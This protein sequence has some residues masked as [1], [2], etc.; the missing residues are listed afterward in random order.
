[1]AS[2]VN[3]MELGISAPKIEGEITASLQHL[4]KR[5]ARDGGG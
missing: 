4:N 2:T 5:F 3:M 1:M